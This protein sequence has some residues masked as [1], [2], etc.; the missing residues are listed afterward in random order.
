MTTISH[1]KACLGEDAAKYAANK[2]RGGSSGNKGTR[3]EDFFMAYKVVKAAAFLV[4][5]PEA[6]DPH[7]QG[8]VFG[9]VDD[10]RIATNVGTE[11]FQ[12]KNK[13]EGV[14]WSSGNHS[15]AKDFEYQVVLSQHCGEP[16]PRTTLVVPSTELV[17]ALKQ[18]MPDE[19]QKHT[20]VEHFP[21]SG[22]V[23]RLVLECSELR[24]TLSTLANVE[25]P[26][27]DVLSGVFGAMLM[28]CCEHPNG[29]TTCELAACVRNMYPGLLRLLPITEDWE[30][31]FRPE[32]KG[33]LDAIN[34]LVY[35][36]KRGYFYWM[37]AGTSG[38]F[39]A[40]ILS[41]EFARFQEDI[42]QSMPKSF[43]KFEEV[44]P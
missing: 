30:R 37:C 9:F 7:V 21:W 4:K 27:P 43:E 34:G 25:T 15:I 19:I 24:E 6:P 31:C 23:N 13:T 35:G 20:Q 2:H 22:T 36:A 12:L 8:Q 41:E 1:I 10:V 40:S 14:S 44:L 3:Y 28:A 17:S 39:S 18:C 11:Y 38:V 33:V 42:I 16:E 29:A 32:F 26:T 5:D